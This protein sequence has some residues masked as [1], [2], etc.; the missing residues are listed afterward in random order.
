MSEE[1]RDPS[2]AV[3]L[4]V[5]IGKAVRV[6]HD[7]DRQATTWDATPDQG[8]ASQLVRAELASTLGAGEHV[9]ALIPALGARYR[10][11]A[12]EVVQR[13]ED[14]PTEDPR[15]GHGDLKCDNILAV[16]DRIF[17]LDLDRTG[18][19]DPA[20]DLGKFF[21][22]LR[23]WGHHHS[24]DVVGLITAFLEGYGPC[25]PARL[26]RAHLVEVLFH[27]KHAA[28]RIPVHAMDWD[29]HVKRHVGEVAALLR[30]RR[31]DRLAGTPGCL[32]GSLAGAARSR[33]G[34]SSGGRGGGGARVEP[35]RCAVDA[36][37]GVPTR[38]PGQG[39]GDPDLHVHCRRPGFEHLVP[40]RLPRRS[41]HA[42]PLGRFRL[43]G[44]VGEVGLGG[45]GADPALS[46]AAGP[47]STG[48]AVRSP[49]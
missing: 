2:R 19:A 48:S 4:L 3:P 10:V 46:R 37:P 38:V 35:A 49:V 7:L 27:L 14:L 22:D 15:L 5:L 1:V 41:R 24:V 25:E 39:R 6:L 47:V 29:V 8:S 9:S 20:I 45:R 28:R 12:A 32:D 33:P 44:G 40:T 31:H 11:L 42:R 13:L 30:R 34:P 26:S 23:W 18:L 36:R 17:L 43:G 16:E 21:A